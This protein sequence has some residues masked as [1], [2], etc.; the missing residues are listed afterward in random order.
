MHEY[1]TRKITEQDAR[2][3]ILDTE[4]ELVMERGN[5]KAVLLKLGMDPKDM[6]GREEVI[7]WVTE[8][9]K[10]G[11]SIELIKKGLRD[12]NIDP[13]LAEKVRKTLS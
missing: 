7:D 5:M 1:Y 9:L 3:R 10:A 12:L 4:K 6:D 13:L 11:E 8:K 2:K